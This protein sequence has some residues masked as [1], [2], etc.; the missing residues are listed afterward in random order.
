MAVYI[1]F[2]GGVN[3]GGKNKINMPEL[4]RAL[5]EI[6]LTRVE[7]YIQSGNIIFESGEGEA[8][9]RAQIEGE[10]KRSFHISV[11]VILRTTD[12]L[13]RLT[14]NCP[15]T[16]A[17]VRL[18]ESLNSEGESL[19]AAL[20]PNEAGELAEPLNSLR[21]E[22]DDFRIMGRDVC[23]LLRHSIRNSKLA[24]SLQKSGAAVT[25]RNW[26]TLRKLMSMAEER[27]DS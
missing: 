27:M 24:G 25:V 14:G 22:D 5:E 6:G 15:F 19:Y 26:K 17:E 20:L 7:T 23:L 9:L 18:S 11:P 4:K 8:A 21:S 12:E 2:L 10:L 16:D 13:G 1:A 3:V